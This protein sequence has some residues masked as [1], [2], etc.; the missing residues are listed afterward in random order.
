MKPIDLNQSIYELTE[1]YPEI[2]GIIKNLGFKDIVS[3]TG[4]KTAGRSMTIPKGCEMKGIPID[5]VLEALVAE[6]FV[7]LKQGEQI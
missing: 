2:V 4:R 7:I 5:M 1:K 3:P 6:G